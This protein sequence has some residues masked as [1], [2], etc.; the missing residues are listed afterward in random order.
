MKKQELQIALEIVKPGLAKKEKI[1]QATSFAFINDYVVTYNDEISIRHPIKGLNIN[2]AI[3]ANELYSLLT[4]LKKDE[5]E[6][7][8][9]ENELIIHSGKTKAG[10]ILQKEIILPLDE[11]G[12]INTWKSL[13]SIFCKHLKFAM[14]ACSRDMNT[15]VITCVHVRKDGVL[16]ATDNYRLVNCT[17]DKIP[18]NNFLLPASAAVEVIKLEPTKIASGNNWVHFQNEN[19]T[20]ISCRIFEGT[21]NDSSAF[22]KIKGAKLLLPQTIPDIL[23]RVMVFAQREF[24]LSEDV[25]ITIENK[26]IK[27][28]A[29]SDT[30]WIEEEANIRYDGEKIE[31]I[32]SP[33]LFRDVL[34]ETNELIMGSN[35]VKFIA[36]D[37]EYVILLKAL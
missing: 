33:Q 34:K 10:L 1:E 22:L 36:E 15:P 24:F 7:E 25:F 3:Q 28:H 23:E 12:E 37:W 19:N 2:G 6:I 14:H 11:I 35:S 31:F 16:E 4:K 21:F 8:K 18:I 26:K 20:I 32:I 17:G 30:G 29:K 5:I 13:P 27:L 9:T